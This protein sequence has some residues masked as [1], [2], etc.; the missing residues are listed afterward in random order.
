MTPADPTVDRTMIDA[1]YADVDDPQKTTADLA[2]YFADRFVDFDRSPAAAGA[3]SDKEAHLA[4]FDALKAGFSGYSHTLN[5]VEETATGKVVVYWT[6]EGNHSGSFF[7]VPASSRRVR[8]NGIDIYTVI[9]GKFAEQRHCEDV[10]GLMAQIAATK[11][12]PA[13]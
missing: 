6:F 3:S 13:G 12:N 11:V 2:A 5:L 10:A 9:D 7:G 8:I 1:F 4:V